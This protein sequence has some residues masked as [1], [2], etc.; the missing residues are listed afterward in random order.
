MKSDRGVYSEKA[1]LVDPFHLWWKWFTKMQVLS[2]EWKSDRV[3][4]GESREE[5]D[6]LK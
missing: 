6:G 2:L 1:I 4:D 3:M 5:K